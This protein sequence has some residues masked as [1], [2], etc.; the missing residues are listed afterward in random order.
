ML[1]KDYYL[2]IKKFIFPGSR[3][4]FFFTFLL[5]IISGLLSGI[6][7]GLYIPVINYFIGDNKS[8]NFFSSLSN[9][10]IKLFHI[11]N[12]FVSLIVVAT[13]TIIL[14]ALITYLT[15]LCSGYLSVKGYRS[16]KMRLIDDLLDRPYQYFIRQRV[17]KIVS[18]IIDQAT[19]ASNTTENI[20]RCLTSLFLGLVYFISLLVI[21]FYLTLAMFIFGGFML[22]L[23]QFFCRKQEKLSFALLDIKHQQS[24]LFTESIIGIKTIK[25]M[26]LEIFRKKEIKSSLDCEKK[27]I[28]NK[29]NLTHLQPLLAKTLTTLFASVAI[30]LG[31][32]VFAFPAAVVIIFLML[33][34]RLGSSLQEINYGWMELSQNMPNIRVVMQ[35][36]NWDE[37]D[38]KFRSHKMLFDFR[39]SIELRNVSF[40]YTG[41]QD[42]LQ[43]INMRILRKQFI[44]LVGPSGE[45]K[46]TLL[47]LII[48]L[49]QPTKGS[50]LYDGL[51]LFNYS[52]ENWCKKIGVVAQDIFLFNDTIAKNISYGD[53]HPDFKHIEESARIAFIHDFIT[54]LKD[55]YDTFIGDR[56]IMLS[57]GQRQRVALARA[58]YHQPKLLIL[59]EATSS[60]DSESERCIQQALERM[61]GSLTIIA[62]AHRLSTIKNADVIYYID[63]GVIK[64]KGTHNELIASDS[65]Y[66]KLSLMQTT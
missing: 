41:H 63:N 30:W 29:H 31:L 3:L 8:S 65:Y 64:E 62:V 37:S 50:I 7:L 53:Q 35:Y 61:Y 4:L 28:F 49:Y 66:R 25:S 34:T 43:D 58:L 55:G 44:A 19:L 60:L 51:L 18:I 45:G 27:T 13:V 40:S 22:F 52:Q 42:V 32:R 23:N 1:L 38:K 15:M 46:T 36:I 5:T 14:G 33:A 20:F 9:R 56:G 26:G 11:P 57:G 24:N 6:G 10:I 17:G 39:E 47:D 54:G 59:D 12:N 48:G 16:V 2:F 21:S